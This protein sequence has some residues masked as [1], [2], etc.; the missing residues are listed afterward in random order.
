[1]RE[2]KT[3]QKVKDVIEQIDN[4]IIVKIQGGILGLKNGNDDVLHFG[5]ETT[6]RDKK[7]IL[8]SKIKETYTIKGH[9]NY[10]IVAIDF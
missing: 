7:I 10:Q 3:G 8:N 4:F 6:D 9:T 5:E 1:M 2:V